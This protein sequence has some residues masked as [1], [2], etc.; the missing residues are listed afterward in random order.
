MKKR[1]VVVYYI[2]KM[3]LSKGWKT[4]VSFRDISTLSKRKLLTYLYLYIVESSDDEM[5]T[6]EEIGESSTNKQADDTRG[7]PSWNLDLNP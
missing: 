2:G 4:N 6:S 1:C 5:S 7:Q 3:L